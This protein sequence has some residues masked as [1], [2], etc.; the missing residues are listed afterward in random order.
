MNNEQNFQYKR[1]HIPNVVKTLKVVQA[2]SS[3]PRGLTRAELVDVTGFTESIIFRILYTMLDYGMILKD[4]SDSR[5][6][7]SKKF[8]SIA[9]DAIGEDNII[10]CARDAMTSIRDK[11][12]ET[13][14]LGILSDKDVIM[15]DQL[16]GKNFF[17]FT[18]K[19][20]LKC[21]LHTSAPA[22]AI[23]AF[24]P[25]GEVEELLRG[26]KFKS[27]TKNSIKDKKSLLAELAQVRKN[28]YAVDC[29]EYL[30]GANCVGVPIFDYQSYPVAAIWLTGPSDRLPE[31]SFAEIGAYMKKLAKEVSLK[32]GYNK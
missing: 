5:Y 15:I 28:G 8:I 1:Y 24:M 18:G 19:V 20:G 6:T 12:I 31:K 30:N 4:P 23:L 21:P 14:M 11:F 13:V 32:L 27:Y 22:K 16:Y 17:S 9:Y 7:V 25:E 3:S 26:Y 2:L 29:Q 10:L